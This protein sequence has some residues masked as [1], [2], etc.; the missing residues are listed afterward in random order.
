MLCGSCAIY[1][2]FIFLQF[3]VIILSSIVLRKNYL[4]LNSNGVIPTYRLK[5]LPKNEALGKFR[6]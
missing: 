4:F 6:E 1:S 2:P 5:Y 3:V